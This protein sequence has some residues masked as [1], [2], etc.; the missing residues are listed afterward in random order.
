V[1]SGPARHTGEGVSGAPHRATAPAHVPEAA[2]YPDEEIYMRSATTHPTAPSRAPVR[3]GAAFLTIAFVFALLAPGVARAATAPSLGTAQRFAVLGGSA[4]TNTGPSTITGDLGVSPGNAVSGF[5]PGLVAG[6]TIHAADAVALQAQRDVTTAYNA[7]AGQACDTVLT[8]QDLG[9]LTLTP[10]VYCYAA[11]AQLTGTLTLDAQGN[12]SAVFIF[13]I[14]STLTT[15]SNATVR[16]I[17][18]GSP[19]NIYWKVGSSATLGTATTFVGNILALTSITL[20]TG[21]NISGRALARNGAVTLDTNTGSFAACTTATPTPTPTATATATATPLPTAT[22]VPP[23]LTPSPTATGIPALPTPTATPAKTA[24]PVPPT[25]TPTLTATGIPALP[26]PTVTTSPPGVPAT[27]VP[28]T[29]TATPAKTATPQPAP[30]DRDNGPAATATPAALATATTLVTPTAVATMPG[31]MPTAST[32]VT[33]TT[34][35][36]S[37][38]VTAATPTGTTTPGTATTTL[39]APTPTAPIIPRLPDSGGGGGQ[40]PQPTVPTLPLVLLAAALTLGGLLLRRRAASATRA[41]RVTK[42]EA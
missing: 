12:P 40:Q 28:A 30:A 35:T 3:A 15:A 13:Q 5:P 32:T 39:P 29:A 11:A 2:H 36:A 24:T 7:L 10:G 25:M 14:G 20:T 37:T 23:T 38:T 9:G 22:P 18:G 42:G 1:A 16:V 34:P 8:G 33:T 27:S 17:N 4:V 6:G 41:A 21:A 26:T 31:T 19:C